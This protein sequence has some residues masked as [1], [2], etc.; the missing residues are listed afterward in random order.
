M[1]ASP[2][3]AILFCALSHYL[4]FQSGS[5]RI[6]FRVLFNIESRSVTFLEYYN[7]KKIPKLKR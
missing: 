1:K 6:S 3:M 2:V 5:S 4:N 7:V